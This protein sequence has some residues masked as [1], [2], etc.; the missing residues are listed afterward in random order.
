MPK[1]KNIK[2]PYG[3]ASNIGRCAIV[4]EGCIRGMKRYDWHVFIAKVFSL[5][6][7]GLLPD[8][9]YVPIVELDHNLAGLCCK[10]VQLDVLQQIQ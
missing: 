3:Y 10:E 5:V 4:D 6:V 8:E 1:S 7:H 9:L 2:L